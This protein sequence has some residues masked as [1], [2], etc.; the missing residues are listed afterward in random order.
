MEREV[1]ETLSDQRP[2]I[3]RASGT[4]WPFRAKARGDLCLPR[5]Q[6]VKHHWSK[7]EA[8]RPNNELRNSLRRE[9][10]LWRL[11]KIIRCINASDLT[12]NVAGPSPLYPCR[13]RLGTDADNSRGQG[14]YTEEILKKKIPRKALTAFG[15]PPKGVSLLHI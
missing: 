7:S 15:L 3:G 5:G 9:Y 4:A 6:K 10:P 8:K 1:P 13:W 11:E 2:V 12:I 14:E